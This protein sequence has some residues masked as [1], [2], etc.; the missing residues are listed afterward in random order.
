MTE[1]PRISE[2]PEDFVVEELPLYPCSGEGEHTF[3]WVEKRQRTTEE[4]ARALAREADVRPRDVGYAGRKD[5]NAVTRQ[6]FSVPALDPAEA[7]TLDRPGFRVLDAARHRNKLRTGH[8]AGNRFVLRVR[9][10]PAP[11]A[12]Q[13]VERAAELSAEGMP[14]RFGDQR[15]GRDGGN[16]ELARAILRGEPARKAGDRRG[17]R[18]MLSALQS[19]VFNE[20]LASRPTPLST[21]EVGDVACL[22]ESGGM[23]LVEDC[24]A[25]AARAEI[26]EISP[27]GPIFGTHMLS[28]EGAPGAREREV[29]ERWELGEGRIQLPRGIR[30]RGGR[31]PL[32]VRPVGL[33]LSAEGDEVT[34]VE[35]TLPPG[36]YVTVLVEEMFGACDRG[37]PAAVS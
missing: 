25:E 29:L 33:H 15:F 27:T 3:L 20:V 7:L 2:S 22:H 30:L 24:A 8:L 18:F 23:F 16:L 37:R 28:A 6:W 21:L 14:N 36:S 19:A 17:R 5:R 35:V 11:L 26:F 12:A 31:R 9:G 10:V 34:R 1:R 13:A 32:R 4:V